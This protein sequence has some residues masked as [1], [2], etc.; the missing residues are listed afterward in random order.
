MNVAPFDVRQGNFVGAGVNMVTRSGSNRLTGSFYH[1]FRNQNWVGTEAGWSDGEPR[2]RS[3]TKNNGGWASVAQSSRTSSS[4][5]AISRTSWRCPLSTFIANNGGEPWRHGDARACVRHVA[6]QPPEEQV[7]IRSGPVQRLDKK[8]P[9]SRFSSSTDYNVNNANKVSFRYN[10][11]KSFTDVLL[12]PST[13]ALGG[14]G[15][16]STNFLSFQNTNYQILENI[17]SGVGE[18][19]ATIGSSISKCVR[20]WLHEERRSRGSRGKIFPFV[21]IFEGAARL[22]PPS[23]SSRL[24]CQQSCATR[25]CSCR[26][27]DEVL[28]HA[29]RRDGRVLRGECPFRQRVLR[30][31][32]AGLGV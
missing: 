4:P 17:K 13:S 14:R 18:W 20:D 22:T 31:L 8:T 24:R 10:H 21:D 9:A 25:R 28:R 15:T 19:N 1:R 5:S 11:L 29:A 32:P 3:T 26:T 12:S 6:S 7:R 16:N 30:L 23:G 2:C 27:T